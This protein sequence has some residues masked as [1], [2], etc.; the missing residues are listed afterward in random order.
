MCHLLGSIV[1]GNLSSCEY[2]LYADQDKTQQL[3]KKK[4]KKCEQQ[5]VYIMFYVLLD[6]SSVRNKVCLCVP[7]FTLS[8]QKCE[9]ENV[10]FI[11]K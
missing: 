4:R 7:A 9:G 8:R 3:R 10:N 11:Y 1:M 2:I 6:W 5:F